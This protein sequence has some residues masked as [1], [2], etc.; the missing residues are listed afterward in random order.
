MFDPPC[1]RGI[2]SLGYGPI[3]YVLFVAH[4]PIATRNHKNGGNE[5][6]RRP[7]VAGILQSFLYRRFCSCAV[8]CS[9]LQIAYG[10]SV[11]QFVVCRNGEE[12]E[13]P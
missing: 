5:A 12:K 13:E 3:G 6:E 2:F 1:P 11:K 10:F 4:Q 7:N 8:R 9:D